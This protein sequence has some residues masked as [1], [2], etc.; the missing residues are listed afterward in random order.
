VSYK[1]SSLKYNGYHNL[2]VLVKLSQGKQFYIDIRGKTLANSVLT[3]RRSSAKVGFEATASMTGGGGGTGGPGSMTGESRLT[4]APSAQSL[5]PDIL[6]VLGAQRHDGFLHLAPVPIG[7]SNL[8][9]S[10][11]AVTNKGTYTD[12][13]PLQKTEL[14]NVSAFPVN[15]E[16]FIARSTNDEDLA[17]DEIVKKENFHMEV[18]RCANSQGLIL[19]GNSVHL[20]WYFYPMEDKDY[21]FPVVIRYFT[22]P[23]LSGP[24]L[25][26]PSMTLNKSAS[27]NNKTGSQASRKGLVSRSQSNPDGLTANTMT[28]GSAASIPQVVYKYL[29]TTIKIRGYD[30]RNIKPVAFESKYIGGEPPICP[31]LQVP[32]KPVY[33]YEDYVHFNMIPQRSRVKRILTLINDSATQVFE[34][35]VDEPSCLLSIDGLLAVTP[36]FGKVDPKSKTIIELTFQ[37]YTQSMI[38]ED[39]IKIMIREIIRGSNKSRGGTRQQIIDRLKARKVKFFIT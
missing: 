23:S 18:M 35:A 27:R 32:D 38:F 17:I 39:H 31:V 14:I 2:P 19:G 20:E 29:V 26:D 24:S 34:F 13:A 11:Y 1:H 12:S 25:L 33:L 4:S 21:E 15:Y 10:G 28:G 7:L 16:V 9:T 3:N 37:G 5:T 6:L 8:S 22:N 30:P 36:I